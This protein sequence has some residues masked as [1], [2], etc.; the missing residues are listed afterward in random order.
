MALSNNT[1]SAPV[2]F[3]L[4]G[5]PGMEESQRWLSFP[6]C[7]L[8]FI[9]LV[10]NCIILFF[11]WTER[12]LHTPMYF[13]LSM[14]AV[15]DLGVSLTTLPTVLRIFCFHSGEITIEACLIQMF[16]VHC[17]AAM[18]SG[19]LV[20]MAFDR[21]MAICE[22]LRY[23]SIL[24]N[25]VLAKIG[26]LILTRGICVVFPIPF[27]TIRFPYCKTHLLS[28]SYCLHQDVIRLACA[29][30]KVNSIYGL[31]A[32]L[33]T[34]GFDSVFIIISYIVII[35][36]VLRITTTDARLKAFSTCISHICAVLIFYIP[37]IGLSVVHRFGAHSS[38]LVPV[39][40]AN[41]YLLL[42]PVL[43]PVIYSIKT[44]EIRT[45]ILKT[46]QSNRI[47]QERSY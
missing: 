42:P 27:L 38:P 41:V 1:Y 31:T 12:S 39:L 4:I 20:A 44:K 18:E 43:N 26:L 17:F 8:Y 10:G 6:L 35:R 25:S 45:R 21:C 13:F 14:L 16:F 7:S 23:T 34:K 30:I 24:T 47:I 29:D 37:L 9:A 22:P 28:H 5:I 46:F 15:T 19:V 33:F 2:T 40:M 3:I 11:I 32:V 36:A